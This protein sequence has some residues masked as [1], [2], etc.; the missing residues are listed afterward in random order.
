MIAKWLA[1]SMQRSFQNSLCWLLDSSFFYEPPFNGIK[2]RALN[3]FLG[4][5]LDH[6]CYILHGVR[7]VNWSNVSMEAGSLLADGAYLRSHGPI[8]IGSWTLIGPQ[9]M[10]VSGGH[11]KRDLA[12]TASSI[13]IGKGVFVG[14]RALILEGVTIGDHAMIGAGAIVTADIPTLAIAVGNPARVIGYRSAP[15]EVWTIVG[16]IK[17]QAGEQKMSEPL[18][19]YAPAKKVDSHVPL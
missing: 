4:A 6:G 3:C 9:A 1:V 8:S 5:R 18:P 14:A 17:L 16:T 7:A 11:A 19:S 15:E 10:L 2:A 12:P 13:T